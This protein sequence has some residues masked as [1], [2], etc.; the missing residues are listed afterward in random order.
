MVNNKRLASAN[1]EKVPKSVIVIGVT[2]ILLIL[3][4]LS[5]ANDYMYSYASCGRPPIS[6]SSFA[7]S[8]S[9]ELPGDEGYGPGP[10]QE[11]FCTEEDAQNAGYRRSNGE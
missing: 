6:A 11:Y 3:G 7:A 10:F 9:Y 8:F 2:L 1:E 4:W 5:G